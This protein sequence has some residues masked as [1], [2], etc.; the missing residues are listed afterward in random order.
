VDKPQF[1]N[2][3][4][5][6]TRAHRDAQA[7]ASDEMYPEFAT[8]TDRGV[9]W[10]DVSVRKTIV[11][12]LNMRLMM[13]TKILRPK[14]YEYFLN[15]MIADP[16]LH[17]CRI[18]YDYDGQCP[19]T[20]HHGTVV[21]QFQLR[22][23]VY[24]ADIAVLVWA[25]LFRHMHVSIMSKDRD[26][27]EAALLLWHEEQLRLAALYA[28]RLRQLTKLPQ[29]PPPPRPPPPFKSLV[30]ACN[31]REHYNIGYMWEQMRRR[32][33]SVPV[34]VTWAIMRG[35]D[36][37]HAPELFPQVEPMLLLESTRDAMD[38]FGLSHE[39][40]RELFDKIYTNVYSSAR[41]STKARNQRIARDEAFKN[42]AH[43]T[44]NYEYW[45]TLDGARQSLAQLLHRD[46]TSLDLAPA[47]TRSTKPASHSS[48]SS[49]TRAIPPLDHAPGHVE[50]EHG[51]RRH[52]RSM[53][54]VPLDE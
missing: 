52:G 24:E 34:H 27:M 6:A 50:E 13:Q 42:F 47:A 30:V 19:L 7:A 46:E 11:P 20:I 40:P 43:V 54:Q 9:E 23:S 14:F 8:I 29:K 53:A 16:R 41:C 35:T 1:M 26:V 45:R 3:P 10:Y 18:I 4:K 39:R 31:D 21:K 37:V 25:I 17:N 38:T 15:K 49:M 5:R 32:G 22:N 51:I 33:P 44:R 48:S 12:E 36:F 2:L 28:E